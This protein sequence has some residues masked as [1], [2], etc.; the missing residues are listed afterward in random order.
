MQVRGL[1][2]PQCALF[3]RL[4]TDTGRADLSVPVRRG[5]A[6]QRHESLRGSGRVREPRSLFADLQ[7]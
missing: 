1:Q 4:Q 6:G 7:K 3:E 2:R 5:A